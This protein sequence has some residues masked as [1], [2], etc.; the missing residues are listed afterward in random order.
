[1]VTM[2]RT[3]TMSPGLDH[4][5]HVGHVN[6]GGV[7]KLLSW[8]TNAS[9]KGVNVARI[10]TSLGADAVAYCLAG[11]ENL[12]QFAAAAAADGVEARI[13]PVP[14][15]TRDNLTLSDDS[16]S[17][18]AGHAAGARLGPVPPD[19]VEALVAQVIGDVEAGDIVT[20][21]GA[22]PDGCAADVWARLASAARQAGAK[23]MVDTQGT[24]LF[25]ALTTGV[26][27]MAKP[28]AEEV[29]ALG[30]VPVVGTNGGP[31]ADGELD[32]VGAIQLGVA[33]VQTMRSLAVDDPIVT[34]GASGM[35]HIVDGLLA[36]SR[37]PVAVPKIV[38]GAGDAFV[39]G[40][41][42]AVAG[43]ALAE[44]DPANFGLA[45][46][47][48]YVSGADLAVERTRMDVWLRNITRTGIPTSQNGDEW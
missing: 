36:L 5:V 40:Y 18:L 16:R 29:R 4:V 28:N 30:L 17:P 15:R 22:L 21:N 2:I 1:M 24:P 34:L 26:A 43:S 46:A 20:L 11:E 33:G 19:A 7:G 14:G 13:V 25:V 38:V 45:V 35:I 9:G 12:E 41:C 44:A 47:A 27:T 3:V 37:C 48:A 6:P 23:V 39:A 31:G 8:R 10:A 32:P 42:A